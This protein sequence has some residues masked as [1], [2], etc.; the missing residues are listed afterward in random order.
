MRAPSSF[1][2]T[3]AGP[4]SR[5]SAARDVLRRLREHRGHRPQR[6]EAEAI[7]TGGTFPHGDLGDIGEVSCEHRSAPDGRDRHRSCLRDRVRHH[8]FERALAQLAEEEPDQEPLL[9]LGRAGEE[10]GE[11]FA[12]RPLR[13]LPADRLK[14]GHGLVDLAQLEGRRRVRSGR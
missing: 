12:P 3:L 13:A 1:H 8:A 9:G 4:A 6:L 5:A 7:E 10:R 14:P 2:S 11:L